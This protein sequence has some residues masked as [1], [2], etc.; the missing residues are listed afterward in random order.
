MK[1]D[2]TGFKKIPGGKTPRITAFTLFCVILLY[3][4]AGGYLIYV[5]QTILGIAAV[6]AMT[7]IP[8]IKPVKMFLLFSGYMMAGSFVLSH[9]NGR[10]EFPGVLISSMRLFYPP[11]ALLAGGVF[12]KTLN[13][14]SLVCILAFFLLLEW[15]IGFLQIYSEAFRTFS[16]NLYLRE[17]AAARH[18][19]WFDS[20][21]H[22]RRCRGT[23]GH[24]NTLGMIA[25]VLNSSV[26]I[27][28]HNIRAARFRNL[29]SILCTL[30]A[31][32]LVVNTQSRTSISFFVLTIML[33]AWWKL[34]EKPKYRTGYLIASC[35][36][37]LSVF[38]YMHGTLSRGLP[39]YAL[40]PRFNVWH[41]RISSMFESSSY[42]DVFTGIFGVGFHTARSFDFF[43]NV[44]LRVFVSSGILGLALFAALIVIV[45][46]AVMRIREND[47]R[48]LAML[49]SL[50]WLAGSAVHDFQEIFKLSSVTFFL[51]GLALYKDATSPQKIESG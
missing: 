6:Y 42:N 20:Y 47:W 29:L 31:A 36:A 2:V 11:L 12:S 33:I 17:E 10:M 51:I 23:V 18:L 43:D 8:V 9:I 16:Y 26:L 50:F 15:A 1:R 49:L 4:A 35:A 14:R 19:R 34:A 32:Y 38:Y 24:P 44:Y 5:P 25:V 41:M 28:S 22:W 13:T 48:H 37:A 45:I 3:P 21:E 40:S 27:L 30:A 7:R 39:F 46:R